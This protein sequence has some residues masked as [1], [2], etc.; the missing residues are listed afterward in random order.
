MHPA[1]MQKTLTMFTHFLQRNTILQSNVA[2]NY[3]LDGL[4]HNPLHAYRSPLAIK[5][6][7]FP[8]C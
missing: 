4:G 6:K 8:A 5:P 1:F 2:C 7:I 3:V